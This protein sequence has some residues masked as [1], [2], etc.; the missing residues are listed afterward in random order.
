MI[1]VT[2]VIEDVS[3][4]FRVIPKD[5]YK[6]VDPDFD[7]VTIDEDNLIDLKTNH[8]YKIV[9]SINENIELGDVIEIYANGIVKIIYS[10]NCNDCSLFITARCNS[11]CIMCP[12]SEISRQIDV[13]PDVDYFIKTLKYL[14]DSINHLTITGGEPFIIKKDLFKVF[15]FIKNERN[16]WN[17][18]LLT[19]ARAFSIDEYFK[20]FV[21]TSPDNIV[22]G[23]PIHGSNSEIHDGIVQSKGAFNQTLVGISRLLKYNYPVELRIVPSLLNI[24]DID[25]I[26]DL[27]IKNFPNVY[28]V[29]FVSLEMLGNCLKNKDRTWIK[30]S[31]VLKVVEPNIDK[32]IVNGINVDLYNFPLCLISN[33]YEHIYKN[34][35]TDNKIVYSD[36]CE[37]CKRKDECGGMFFSSIKYIE[38]ELKPF[39]D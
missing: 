3:R 34:S 38:S 31:D 10:E 37:T 28:K 22:L 14:P 21:E 16:D 39:N 33:K 24:N 30:A 19:N 12:S 5:E 32:L 35:I 4:L 1:K 8:V 18:L 2:G 36:R 25:N 15:N 11:N 23:I 13:V 26:V 6:D 17:C 27:I 29:T 7:Y 20:L 9:S